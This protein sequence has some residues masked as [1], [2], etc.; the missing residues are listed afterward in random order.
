V[1]H[2]LDSM[3]HNGAL[4]STHLYESAPSR[5]APR[6]RYL[7]DS[8][9]SFFGDALEP[10]LVLDC[11]MPLSDAFQLLHILKSANYFE[12]HN[13]GAFGAVCVVL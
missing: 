4:T 8:A 6:N 5:E 10:L 3:Q 2:R 11:F 7:H 9:D 1:L 13:F 12:L